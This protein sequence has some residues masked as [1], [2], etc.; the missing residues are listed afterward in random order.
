MKRKTYLLTLVLF[1]LFF[2]GSI[3]FISIVNL[4]T[5]L[6]N[7]RSSC[8][9]EHDFI[10]AALAKDL[11][12]LERRD[13]ASES[14]LSSLFSSYLSYYGKQNVYLELAQN[15]QTQFSSLP[16]GQKLT[17][18]PQIP[19]VGQRIISTVTSPDRK[20][21][22]IS[23]ALPIP[24]DTYVLSY[25]YDLSE[26]TASW[27]QMTSLLFLIGIAVS[28]LLA[29][30]LILLLNRI[31]KPLKQISEAS[32]SI[33]SGDYANRLSVT[34]DD[35]LAEM[36]R[37]FN[38]MAD[39]IENQI[40]Q[41]AEASAQKQRFIDNFAHELRTPLTSIYGYA[42]YIQKAA[43][44]E[45]DKLEATGYIMSESHRLQNIAYRLLDLAS[46]RSGDITFA[47]VLMEELLQ[48]V[49]ETMHAKAEE[50]Q[51][52]LVYESGFKL[53]DGD[54]DLLQS[55]L[56]N[57]MENAIKACTT[58]GKVNLKSFMQDG[59][60]VI[61]VRDNGRGMT[62]EQISHVT[63]AFYR[64]D[65]AR[66]RAEGGVGLGLSICE[67]IAACHGA[68]LSFV[69]QLGEGTITTI[70]FYNSLTSR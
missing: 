4:N 8:L 21:I 9:R 56:V 15:S 5:S 33:A 69:S 2:N 54:P 38:N 49:S 14:A 68:R 19:P 45:A 13:S 22:G 48:S 52:T 10:T 61:E 30:C 11:N 55:L 62:E 64:V 26:L 51:V 20:Y 18:T 6:N 37:S 32:Q 60:K 36:A 57:L 12:A 43:I 47:P 66:S 44:T 1:L 65:K 29:V 34:G 70:T 58:G 50:K 39:A 35:E 31:F 7:T 25:Y 17:K 16:P 3:L 28:S 59:N 63:E 24:Y 42:E 53:L 41:L 23:G 46:L 40:F 67:L 27:R